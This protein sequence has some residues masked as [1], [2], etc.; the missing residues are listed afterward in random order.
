MN[1]ILSRV[2]VRTTK[3]RCQR[4][5]RA[6]FLVAAVATGMTLSGCGGQSET[7][8][9]DADMTPLTSST[10]T[11]LVSHATPPGTTNSELSE[12]QSL[13]EQTRLAQQAEAEFE[14]A[15]AADIWNSIANK[16]EQMHGTG[17]WQAANAHLAA[18]VA[19]A[20]IGFDQSQRDKL[21]EI[22]RL[23]KQITDAL[24]ANNVYVALQLANR[25]N[26][27]TK[28]LFGE[29]SATFGKQLLQKG[30]LEMRAMDNP[31]AIRTY[32]QAISVLV[33]HFSECHPEVCQALDQLGQLYS[34]IG[35]HE[36]AIERLKAATKMAMDIWGDDSIEY[37]H[38]ANELGVEFYRKQ[39]YQTALKVLK[40]AE[41]IRRHKL[42]S[43]NGLVGH[44]LLN[45]GM[46]ELELGSHA[47]AIDSLLAA[48]KIFQV[49]QTKNDTLRKNAESK[50]ATA[51][52]LNGQPELAE[53]ILSDQLATF[54]S[55]HPADHPAVADGQYKLAIA[56]ARQGKYQQAEPLLSS[57]MASQQ[58]GLGDSNRKTLNT[59]RAYALLLN[60]TNRQGEAQQ[61]QQRI[62]VAQQ[63]GETKLR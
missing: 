33:K 25:S 29:D 32:N 52:T 8:S 12:I 58:A 7:E 63:N 2:R 38:R 13:A 34:R 21:L 27:I 24:A 17:C 31:N 5:R 11:P 60:R 43:E 42:G 62:R 40:A 48:R 28:E 57:A 55:E 30:Q 4:G 39:E 3:Q 56:L 23:S 26:L 10:T 54:Q 35:D 51:Y 44:S 53:P 20:E 49:D 14:F 15:K 18:E 22:S 36:T 50:L 61:I 1:R 9:T 46:V 59:M 45:L 16:L 37:A 19:E 41:V 6:L 47:N